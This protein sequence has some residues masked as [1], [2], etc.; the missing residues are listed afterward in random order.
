MAP[1]QA[2]DL[3]S[4]LA[5]AQRGL[6][7]LAPPSGEQRDVWTAANWAT[8]VGTGAIVAEALL[9]NIGDRSDPRVELLFMRTLA[10]S[11]RDTIAELLRAG[12]VVELLAA[13]L[14]PAMQGLLAQ[15]AA[16]ASELHD[17]FVLDGNTSTLQ[18][19]GLD[20]FYGGLELL[21]GSPNPQVYKSMSRDHCEMPDSNAPFDMPN[22]KAWTTASIEWRFVDAPESGA[23]GHGAPFE[24][25]P[26]PDDSRK[27]LAFLHFEPA[28]QERNAALARAGEPPVSREEVVGV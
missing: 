14:W 25:Y 19:G 3:A 12:N 2:N 4:M 26:K 13:A 10:T 28:L 5:A 24:P 1:G 9:M 17:K 16:S 11:S 18:F 20:R 23:D 27:P 8:S 22:G 21:V 7:A 6:A 15:Q